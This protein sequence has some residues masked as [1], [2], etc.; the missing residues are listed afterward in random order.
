MFTILL[1]VAVA[2]VK[3]IV[4]LFRIQRDETETVGDEF[5]GEYGGVGFDLN[6]ING[7]GRDFG[8][9]YAAKGV[10]EG[11]VYII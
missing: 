6:E 8:Q 7:H 2:G 9:N 1:A 4:D 10:G 5:I 11:E 3:N